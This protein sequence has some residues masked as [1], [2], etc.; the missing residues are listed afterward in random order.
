MVKNT[1]HYCAE[2]DNGGN[3]GEEKEDRGSKRLGKPSTEEI[4][5]I[6][7]EPRP[8]RPEMDAAKVSL[9]TVGSL[10]H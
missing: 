4:H 6:R 1:F 10:A 7:Q 3:V 2:R 8:L 5:E 9:F